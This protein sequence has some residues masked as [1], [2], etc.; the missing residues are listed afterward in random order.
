VTFSEPGE[1]ILRVVANDSSGPDGGDFMC[2]WT[3]AE[4]RV[5]VE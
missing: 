2:C 4:V 5:K 1:Y 3:N